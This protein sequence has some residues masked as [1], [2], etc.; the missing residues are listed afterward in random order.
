[1]AAT[2]SDDNYSHFLL[3]I[4]I[5]AKLTIDYKRKLPSVS[6]D[7]IEPALSQMIL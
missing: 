3:I 1:M 7:K 5:V 4:H 2:G 6:T